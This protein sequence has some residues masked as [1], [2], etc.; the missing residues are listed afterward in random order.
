MGLPPVFPA[1]MGYGVSVVRVQR[2]AAS[3]AAVFALA[4]L[5]SAPS[6]G[7]GTTTAP[8]KHVLVYFVIND[9]KIAYEILRRRRAA[10]TTS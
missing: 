2:Y 8:G 4:L 6:L 7:E 9:K 1:E 10:G 5:V 3:A